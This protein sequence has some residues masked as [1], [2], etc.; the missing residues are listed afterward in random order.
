MNE[1]PWV[2]HPVGTHWQLRYRDNLVITLE[3][4][5]YYCDRGKWIAKQ[6]AYD[7]DA[8]D[9]WPRYFMNLDRAKPECYEWAEWR[10]TCLS[11][12]M[13]CPQCKVGTHVQAW[14]SEQHF[15]VRMGD[16]EIGL[17]TPAPQFNCLKCGLDWTGFDAEVRRTL[18]TES[19]QKMRDRQK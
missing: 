14:I 19:E 7:E 4:R 2:W 12:N 5:P 6:F 9:A 16:T 1:S 11:R 15:T 10:L 13:E 18:R 3:P 8:A 17:S